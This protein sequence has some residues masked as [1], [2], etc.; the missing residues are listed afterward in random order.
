MATDKSQPRIGVIA[1]VGLLSI[2][3]VVGTRAAL[4][5]YFDQSILEEQHRK[6]GSAR[7]EALLSVRESEMAR[8]DG[9][10]LPIGMAM[11]MLAQM[12]RVNAPEAVRPG[13]SHDTAPLA[14]WSQ[15]PQEVP[16]GMTAPPPEPQAA[17]DAGAGAAA[18][19]AAD[20]AAPG[21]AKGAAAPGAGPAPK[22][23]AP[24][25]PTKRLTPEP[26]PAN[27]KPVEKKK[28]P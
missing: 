23:A 8:L 6:V 28:T 14:G 4:V 26:G 3:T 7:P 19:D 25:V 11:Q 27:P 2:V 21:T 15:M 13:P 5:A 17:A 24:A 16:A 12:G 20:A 9:G 18:A 10:G 1:S 22:G